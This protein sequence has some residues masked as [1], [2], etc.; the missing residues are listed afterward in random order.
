MSRH[1]LQYVH[2]LNATRC[3][4]AS[5]TLTAGFKSL[6]WILAG[7]W[8]SAMTSLLCASNLLNW[9]GN[10]LVACGQIALV[11]DHTVN[12]LCI[13]QRNATSHPPQRHIEG[14]ARRLSL[15]NFA[16]LCRHLPLK[17][18]EGVGVA[19]PFLYVTGQPPRLCLRLP[20]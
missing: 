10:P 16:R 4:L 14:S 15:H 5:S 1:A 20:L 7:N 17:V 2:F 12:Q 8:G 19:H 13:D 18:W 3:Q 6:W 9:L 11:N